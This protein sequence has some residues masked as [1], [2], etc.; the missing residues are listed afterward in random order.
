M[1]FLQ[2]LTMQQESS[3]H[4]SFMENSLFCELEMRV[5]IG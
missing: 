5:T 3:K 1:K 4:G 2:T